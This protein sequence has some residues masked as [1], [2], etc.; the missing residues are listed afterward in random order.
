MP[1]QIPRIWRRR[2]AIALGVIGIIMLAVG[3]ATGYIDVSL[4]GIFVGM[5]GEAIVLQERKRPG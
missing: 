3:L 2:L 1:L 4:W 5:T